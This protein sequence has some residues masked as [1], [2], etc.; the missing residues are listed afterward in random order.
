MRVD[1]GYPDDTDSLS[2]TASVY[3][4]WSLAMLS[5]GITL[6]VIG[7]LQNSHAVSPAERDAA[8]QALGADER[9]TVKYIT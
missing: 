9:F 5:R 1:L 7:W 2:E 4:G 8:D 3:W 6:K